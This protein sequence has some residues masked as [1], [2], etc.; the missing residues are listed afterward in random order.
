M[1]PDGAALRYLSEQV[2][3]SPAASRASPRNSSPRLARTRRLAARR[4]P[5]SASPIRAHDPGDDGSDFRRDGQS[6][7]HRP[8]HAEATRLD[9]QS[10][11]HARRAPLPRVRRLERLDQIPSALVRARLVRNV[12]APGQRRPAAPSRRLTPPDLSTRTSSTSGSRTRPPSMQMSHRR[13][14]AEPPLDRHIRCRTPIRDLLP[15]LA[16]RCGATVAAQPL[17]PRTSLC[18]SQRRAPFERHH[19]RGI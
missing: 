10:L 7:A 9:R 3:V 15:L 5:L 12:L 18:E 14:V 8:A 13:F 16:S 6:R 1:H 4:S 2:V 17:R 11:P 19:D